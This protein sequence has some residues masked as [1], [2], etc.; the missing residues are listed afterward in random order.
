M[1]PHPEVKRAL[2]D[3]AMARANFRF[4]D[5][6]RSLN[7]TTEQREKALALLGEGI[8]MGASGLD[9]KSLSLRVA[10]SHA[11]NR[12]GEPL[13]EIVGEDGVKRFN[14]FA[15]REPALEIAVKMAGALWSTDAPLNS[16]QADEL[17]EVIAGMRKQQAALGGR[18]NPSDLNW[19]AVIDRAR[20]FLAPSQLAAL[21]GLQAEQKFNRALNQPPRATPTPAK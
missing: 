1:A 11:G 19:D 14:E 12:Y 16:A 10:I 15:W 13:R 18:V 4:G 6:L 5:F 17:V 2:S 3:Y 9:G 20:G 7:L 8:G 21:V